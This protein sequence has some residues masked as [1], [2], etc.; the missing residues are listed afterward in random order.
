[1]E[2]NIEDVYLRVLPSEIS[3]IRVEERGAITI[4]KLDWRDATLRVKRVRLPGRVDRIE[5]S[6]DRID[7]SLTLENDTVIIRLW[8]EASHVLNDL[9]V[10]S[11]VEVFGTLRFYRGTVYVY[12]IFARKIDAEHLDNYD[13]F[14]G[15]DR[16]LILRLKG[17]K[18]VEEGEG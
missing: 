6:G 10:G 17:G 14:I 18:N 11:L 3:N 8:G 12:P 7:C 5:K 13:E 16:T 2:I 15:R 1:M 9:K 4:F